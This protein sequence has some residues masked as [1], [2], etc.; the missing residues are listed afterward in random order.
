MKQKVLIVE[1]EFVEANY[2]RSMLERSGYPVCGI[3]RSVTKAMYLL[4][5]ERPYLV[6]LDIFLSG[7]ATGID[8]A[9]H[10]KEQGIA[11]VYLSANSNDEVLNGAKATEPYGFLEKPFR[12]NDLRIM[13]EIATYRH[14]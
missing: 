3:A 5:R 9:R 2:L 6:L 4:Q 10:L 7:K 8:L 12:E 11:F 14:E 13:L 1:D